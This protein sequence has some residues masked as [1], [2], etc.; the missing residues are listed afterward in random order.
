[1][2]QGQTL[3]S[4]PLIIRGGKLYRGD[5]EVRPVCGDAEMISL[6]KRYDR[7]REEYSKYGAEVELDIE[8]RY[9]V[10]FECVCG[11]SISV[12]SITYP[13]NG[14]MDIEDAICDDLPQS[15]TCRKCGLKYKIESDNEDCEIRAFLKE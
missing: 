13:S 1:M 3:K 14:S 7:L 10:S 12:E 8:V 15:C 5:V 6:V 11:G 9:E 4:D 2:T